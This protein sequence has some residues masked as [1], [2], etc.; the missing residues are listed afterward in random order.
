MDFSAVSFFMW[1]TLELIPE[2]QDHHL[3]NSWRKM[4]RQSSP[5][6][7]LCLLLGGG[8]DGGSM[9]VADFGLF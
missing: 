5:R 7:R 6:S 9:S 3:R 1:N 4:N 8:E 2:D